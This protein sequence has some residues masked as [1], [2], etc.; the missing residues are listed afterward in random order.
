VPGRGSCLDLDAPRPFELAL[1]DALRATGLAL[2]EGYASP[3]PWRELADEARRLERAGGFRP[4]GVGR[5]ASLRVRP[6]VRSDGVHWLDP[7]GATRAQRRA[8]AEMERLR[9]ALNREL[10]LGLF[11]FEAHFAHYAPG[12]FYRTHLDRF[13]IDSRRALSAVLYLND[14]WSEQDGGALRLYLE[15]PQRAP[16]L[17][18]LPRGGRLVLF[19]SGR[20]HHEVLA[21]RRARYS[22]AGWFSVRG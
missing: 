19:E 6:D 4:A 2:V 9:R 20:F 16:W 18:V 3:F 14:A 21:A 15:E 8:F 12:A 13:A 17:D 5:G 10:V 22:L 1:A 7:P 11:D